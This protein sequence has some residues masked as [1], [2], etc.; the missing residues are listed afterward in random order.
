MTA[1][2]SVGGLAAHIGQP[3]GTSRPIRITQEMINTFASVTADHQW[4]HTDPIRA[5]QGPHGTT[6]AHG[7]LTLSLLSTFVEDLLQVDHLNATINY[8]LNRV[9]FPAPVLVDSTLHCTGT[10]QSVD[11]LGS[12]TQ[13]VAELAVHSD[14]SP[15]VVCAAE[16]VFRLF[17]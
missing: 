2:T 12:S 1:F 3:L 8:G 13:I 17:A 15:K 4:I 16:L 11:D 9:R 7:F 10:I 14:T 6:I 5:S